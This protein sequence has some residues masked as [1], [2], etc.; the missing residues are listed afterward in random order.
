MRWLALLLLALLAIAC[1]RDP[2][3]PSQPRADS[4]VTL[5][6]VAGPP[7]C[8]GFPEEPCRYADKYE[9]RCAAFGVMRGGQTQLATASHCVPDV[10]NRSTA[11]RFLAPSG[12]GH[13]KAY[14]VERDAAADVAYLALDDPVMV[15]P[16]RLGRAPL[17]GESVW[18]YSPIYRDRS[19]GR[20]TGWL[21]DDWF[22]TDQTVADGWSGSPVLDDS[23]AAVGVVSRCSSGHG[24]SRRCT[25]GRTVVTAA[26]CFSAERWLP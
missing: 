12:W 13:G 17:V 6:R 14:L 7:P 22:E 4:V 20:V 18:S 21:G 25:P 8:L 26:H 19:S 11:L 2:L 5:L 15:S 16:L 24:T 1:A 3:A 10:A 9:P 23:G